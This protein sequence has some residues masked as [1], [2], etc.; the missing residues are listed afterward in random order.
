L[1]PRTSPNAVT[2]SEILNWPRAATSPPAPPPRAQ[3]PAPPSA[4]TGADPRPEIADQIAV[5]GCKRRA[6][7]QRPGDLGGHPIDAEEV[8]PADPLQPEEQAVDLGRRRRSSRAAAARRA[9]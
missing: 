8:G 1:R 2:V 6:Q 3:M 5:D 9:P 7:R 4:I